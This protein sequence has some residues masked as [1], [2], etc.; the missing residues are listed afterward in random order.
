MPEP[1]GPACGPCMCLLAC[2]AVCILCPI[3]FVAEPV[4]ANSSGN[5]SADKKLLDE[6]IVDDEREWTEVSNLNLD[7]PEEEEE[8]EEGEEVTLEEPKSE[9]RLY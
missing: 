7:E 9:V 8:E 1:C 6:M 4:E 3:I 5:K 2:I